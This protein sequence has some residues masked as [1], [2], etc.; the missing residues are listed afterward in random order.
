MWAVM[1]WPPP[2]TLLRVLLRAMLDALPVEKTNGL[3][4]EGGGASL[5]QLGGRDFFVAD[6]LE[7]AGVQPITRAVGAMIHLDLFERAE[8]MSL[9]FDTLTTWAGAFAG[10]VH[11]YD[12]IALDAQKV[13]RGHILAIVHAFQLECVEPETTAAAVAGVHGHAAHGHF[14]HLKVTGRA[15]HEPTHNMP[16]RECQI[17]LRRRR[18]EG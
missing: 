6:L 17:S 4:G 12:R 10:V 8:E 1:S 14:G 5:G 9:E 16:R 18:D 2:L 3:H 15:F 7:F 11:L 13:F